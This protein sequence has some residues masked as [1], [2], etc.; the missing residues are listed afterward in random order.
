MQLPD[1]VVEDLRVRLKRAGGRCRLWRRCWPKAAS[2]A[3]S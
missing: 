1:E 2:V 3:T